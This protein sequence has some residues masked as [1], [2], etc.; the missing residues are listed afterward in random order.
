MIWIH[1]QVGNL[2]FSE[3]LKERKK[4]LCGF[5]V[6]CLF[7]RKQEVCISQRRKERTKRLTFI[8]LPFFSSLRFTFPVLLQI[9]VQVKL[10]QLPS[11]KNQWSIHVT[12]MGPRREISL[13]LP[14]LLATPQK[15]RE[16]S[17]SHNQLELPPTHCR[18]IAKPLGIHSWLKKCLPL[19][20]PKYQIGWLS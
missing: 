12:Y 5:Q 11:Y 19:P 1:I 13:Q 6:G 15:K 9:Q 8:F 3:L 14:P 7:P 16:A 18:Q 20:A 4:T 2:H 10:A 17:H